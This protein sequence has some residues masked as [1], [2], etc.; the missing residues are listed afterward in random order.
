MSKSPE[1]CEI[2]KAKQQLVVLRYSLLAVQGIKREK[3]CYETVQNPKRESR[4]L[5]DCN[6]AM[7]SPSKDSKDFSLHGWQLPGQ[8][9]LL[10][11]KHSFRN[12]TVTGPNTAHLGVKPWKSLSFSFWPW[13]STPADLW[14]V[15]AVSFCS[16]LWILVIWFSAKMRNIMQCPE[17]YF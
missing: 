15:F 16:S 9:R 6:T 7:T 14:F 2:K 12:V 17:K 13:N 11:K 10:W 1:A 3:H 5:E 8:Q 4:W